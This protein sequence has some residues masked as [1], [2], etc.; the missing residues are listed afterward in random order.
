MLFD[1]RRVLRFDEHVKALLA[2]GG[3]GMDSCTCRA[4][5]KTHM[6]FGIPE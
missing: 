1:T 3:V 2:P 5:T 4:G 6:R